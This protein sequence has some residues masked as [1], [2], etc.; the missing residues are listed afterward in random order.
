MKTLIKL[1]LIL[2]VTS[3]SKNTKEIIPNINYGYKITTDSMSFTPNNLVCSVGDTVFFELNSYHNAVEV[4][5]YVYENNLS[6]ILSGGFNIDFG[7]DTFIIVNQPKTHYYICQP[8]I[9]E[10]M[11]GMIIV[12]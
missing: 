9:D 1:T 3:C 8:H 4:S 12:E 6:E 7:M 11:K 10:G 5:Q 2:F